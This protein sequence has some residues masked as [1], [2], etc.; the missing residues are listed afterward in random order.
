MAIREDSPPRR[1]KEGEVVVNSVP[2]HCEWRETV[3]AR[4]QFTTRDPS[5]RSLGELSSEHALGTDI[6]HALLHT[7]L[8][9]LSLAEMVCSMRSCSVTVAE[10]LPPE[11]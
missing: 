9:P 6:P 11:I 7:G 10:F 8:P 5:W 3:A 1:E 2:K 4:G